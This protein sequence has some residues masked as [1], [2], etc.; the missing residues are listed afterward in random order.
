M[1]LPIQYRPQT[2]PD[3]GEFKIQKETLDWNPQETAL[4]VCDMWDTHWCRGAVARV[5]ELLP[6]MERVLNVAQEAGIFVI[7]APSDTIEFYTDYPQYQLAQKAQQAEP[8]TRPA[9][10]DAR[11][12]RPSEPALPVDAKDGGCTEEPFCPQGSPWRRQHPALTIAPQ[13]AISDSGNTVFNLCRE[14][15]IENLIIMG[16]HTNMCVLG[17]SFGIR[18][19][20]QRGMNVLL[21]RDLTDTMYNPRSAPF[22]SHFR[23]TELVIEHIERYWCPTITSTAF[24]GTPPFRFAEDTHTP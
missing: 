7:H 13:D 19:M 8:L 6:T 12:Q 2:A 24:L 23:G 20:V 22:V 3:S 18:A 15:Q 11:W 17:R 10:W 5:E 1:L 9:L 14:R 21:I 16:V 4:L